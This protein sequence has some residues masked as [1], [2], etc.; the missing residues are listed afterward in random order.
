VAGGSWGPGVE[1]ALP[2]NA[3]PTNDDATVGSVSCA[4]A[5]NCS[6][7][8]WYTDSSGSRE[9]L[10]LTETAG[11]WAIGVEAVLPANANTTASPGNQGTYLR[12]VS[13]ASA[14][15]CSAIG[16]YV[17][18][19]GNQQGLLLTETA[20]TWSAGVEAAL[21]ADAASSN[22]FVQWGNLSCASAGN[23]TA[24]GLYNP[25]GRP[26][27]GL[28]LTET[29]GT[30]SAGVEAVPPVP[31]SDAWLNSVSC[32]SAG[33]CIAVGAYSDSSYI[34]H[35]LLL[36][37]T[38]GSWA[39]GVEAA[40]PADGANY[41][42]EVD[43]VSCA[44]AGNCTAVGLYD[45]SYLG[46]PFDTEIRGKG[47]LL[48]ET[49]GSW[50]T[51][52]EAALPA[53]ADS[54]D[55][56]SATYPP[57][58]SCPSTG[59]CS[60]AGSYYDTSSGGLQGLLL[61]ETAGG[62]ASGVEALPPNA[63]VAGVPNPGGIDAVSCAS[64]G[65]CGALDTGGILLTETAGS[66][67]TGLE[68]NLPAN[69]TPRSS[70]LYSVSCPSIGDCNAVGSYADGAGND[71]GLLIGGS[72]ASV[73]LDIS[74][75]GTG[76]GSVS[77][78]PTG[79]DCGS[80]CSASFA[81]GTALTLTATASPGSRFSGWSGGGCSG[82]GSCEPNTAISEQTVTAT[83]KLLPNCVVPRVKGKALKSAEHAVRAHDCGLGKIEHAASRTVK[84]G[85][86]ISQRPKPGRRL[87]NGARVNL[88]VSKGRR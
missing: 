74:K 84:K 66:W 60:V 29:G 28:L 17:D 33:N 15:N 59:N 37:E 6:G 76:S 27:Q 88:V 43:S 64:P 2:A 32:V 3:A 62:W 10:L 47:L 12:S 87:Q 82:T 71:G 41:G 25:V 8:G 72:G 23:C 54:P 34:S 57:A 49:A 31:D 46:G 5:G 63:P 14:G 45:I 58:V 19:S 7:V 85:R 70:Y 79:I 83:F 55:P 51:G 80:T 42:A 20:G 38:G 68:P 73:T 44:S 1:A 13:C 78:A 9:G 4:S 48:T 61:N 35:G 40:Q 18:S 56:V 22:Q 36:T 86:V 67:A 81:A 52:V 24:V 50:A 65:N 26:F 30:W 11:I 16:T 53:N 39:P 69:A 77:S 75:S 21:P